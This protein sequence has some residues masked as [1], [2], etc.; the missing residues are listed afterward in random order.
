[1]MRDLGSAGGR[2]GAVLTVS[3]YSESGCIQAV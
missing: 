2:P 1:M 3:G